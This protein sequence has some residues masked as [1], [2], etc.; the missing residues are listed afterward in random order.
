VNIMMEPHQARQH[1]TDAYL[2]VAQGDPTFAPHV[3][4]ALQVEEEIGRGG[5]GLVY[6]VHDRRLSR[7]AALKVIHPD[8]Q[9][10]RSVARFLRESEITARLDHPA[11]PPV[12]EAGTDTSGRHYMLM[13]LVEG[14]PLHERIRA[15]HAAGGRLREPGGA[16][17]KLLEALIKV[18][19]AVAYAH[20]QGIVHR[21]LKPANVMVGRFGEVLVMDWGLARDLSAPDAPSTQLPSGSHAEGRLTQDGSIMGT[22]GYMAPE[23]AAGKP[24][25]PRSDVFALG[26]ML[27]EILTGSPPLAPGPAVE[28]LGALHDGQLVFPRDARADVPRELDAIA[29][30]A[31]TLTPEARTPDAETFVADLRAYL[32]GG[33]VS[34]HAYGLGERLVRGARRRPGLLISTAALAAV[35]AIGGLA[36]MQVARADAQRQRTEAER[37]A[38]D[39][40]RERAESE[41]ELARAQ[42]AEAEA[43]QARAEQDRDQAE[44]RQRD[45]EATQARFESALEQL[46]E[47]QAMLHR[48]AL[49]E[50]IKDVVERALASAR[51]RSLCWSAAKI[52]EEAALKGEARAL[53]A[54]LVEEHPPGY[55][56]LHYL[57]VLETQEGPANRYT[58]FLRQLV[59][60]AEARG[61]V[62][63]WV[64]LARG[65]REQDPRRALALYDEALRL[66]PRFVWG[67]INRGVLKADELGDPQGAIADYDLALS[68]DPRNPYA[69]HNR[70]ATRSNLGD[71]QAAIDDFLLALQIQP[72]SFN[73]H[74]D[75]GVARFELG[76]Y[77]SAIQDFERASEIDP[78]NAMA[79]FNRGNCY[80]RLQEYEPA[81][82]AFSEAIEADPTY[83][84][85]YAHRGLAY[86]I[87]ERYEEA[88]ADLTTAIELA[89]AEPVAYANRAQTRLHLENYQGALED[90]DR[91]LT[92]R[93]DD[94]R[95]LIDRGLALNGLDDPAGAARAFR[96]ILELEPD[97]PQAEAI[98]KDIEAFEEAA[99]EQGQE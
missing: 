48:G 69:L 3:G 1:A 76:D 47:A 55:R 60:T 82:E 86:L 42:R 13:K 10:P 45:V 49:P 26:A 87:L 21:D 54:A 41:A 29:R 31:L 28:R 39:R 78:T 85:P 32:G 57:H 73:T 16:L 46:S 5:M 11:I 20:A 4:S 89:P 99:R 67:L 61:D 52:Y 65:S 23:M 33:E 14:S 66:S 84:K 58:P 51:S 77:R 30:S 75:L 98:R 72:R 36:L 37:L 79:L 91:Y 71:Q 17:R 59:E 83:R 22:I 96:R 63:E 6:R 25:D 18:G 94:P 88:E 15:F 90:A 2:H 64:L 97:H 19:E 35:A 53:L 34:A 27:T 8:R 40:E 68:L 56:E 50:E 74:N 81:A 44:S 9:G 24:A 38:A 70:G 93:P 43:Q 80:D 92:I 62:N 95:V 12:Y 7:K